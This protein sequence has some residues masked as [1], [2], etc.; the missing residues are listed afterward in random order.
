MSTSFIRNALALAMA[1][2]V[3]PIA[4]ADPSTV[5]FDPTGTGSF[6]GSSGI[7][8]IQQFDWQSSGDLLIQNTLPAGSTNTCANCLGGV[9]TTFG[10]WAAFAAVGDIITFN[11]HAHARLNA[12]LSSGGANIAPPTLSKNGSTCLVPSN[13]FEITAALT[14]EERATLI[15]PGMMRFDAISPG[16]Y[17]FFIGPPNSV[18]AD[19]NAVAPTNFIDGTPF[20]EGDLTSVSG[21]FGSLIAPP[22]SGSNVTIGSITS[23]NN[24][25]IQP[26]TGNLDTLISAT[27]DTLA[28][29]PSSLEARVPVGDPVGLQPYIRLSADLLLKGDANS[30]F[31]AKKEVVEGCRFTGGGNDESLNESQSG[32]ADANNYTFGGQVGAPSTNPAVGGPFG[33]WTH[34]QKAGV[35]DD[36]VFHAGTHSAPKDTRIDTVT[37][38][39]QGPCQPAAANADFKQ[40][41]F[42][43]T[44][45]FRS[46]KKGGS[47]NGFQV[48]TDQRGGGT[49]HRF[50]V[51]LVDF[52]EPGG[53]ATQGDQSNATCPALP[54][55]TTIIDYGDGATTALP[56]CQQCADIYE[57]EIF[58]A[59]GTGNA[60][61]VIYRQRGYIDGGN[62]QIHPP[63]GQ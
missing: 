22:S 58:G 26:D 57:I 20:L 23:Y 63:V 46:L 12:M 24:S 15:A 49:R 39:D 11:I 45:S 37:C 50:N 7:N 32:A 55:I 41:L 6:G 51:H 31:F 33:E 17:K 53:G 19:T 2:A 14:G 35:T 16:S 47:V 43:G 44:G 42:S 62:I 8:G 21:T 52:G 1:M 10:Q 61:M 18:V 3:M 30:R 9:A 27:F 36:F 28:K 60:G 5:K 29:L 34:H 56:I 48:V 4:H 13:C 40:L 54:D 25:Y 38:G 59:I